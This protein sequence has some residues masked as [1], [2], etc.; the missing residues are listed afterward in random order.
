MYI[1]AS[2]IDFA[3]ALTDAEIG[4]CSEP[5]EHAYACSQGHCREGDVGRGISEHANN[6]TDKDLVSDVVGGAYEHAYDGRY[7]VGRNKRKKRSAAKRI[8][9]AFITY[10]FHLPHYTTLPR[11]SKRPICMG[12]RGWQGDGSSVNTLEP[13]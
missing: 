5:E 2:L 1:P 4:G 12:V 11:I 7:S 10:G 3:C 13:K 8:C 6:V 9:V